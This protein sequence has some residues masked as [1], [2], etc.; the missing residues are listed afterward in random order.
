M[1]R[2]AYVTSGEAMWRFAGHWSA[3]D[4]EA[5]SSGLLE[6]ARSAALEEH[7]LICERCM[8]ELTRIEL[9]NF[10][11][12][13]NNGPFY[14]RITLLATGKFLARHWGKCIEGGRE[15][16]TRAGAKA[17]LLRSFAQ[18]FPEHVCTPRCGPTAQCP[19]R[20]ADLEN[21]SRGSGRARRR[22][23]A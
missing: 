15:F 18:M 22:L 21:L 10:V 17:Y 23:R 11:H 4:L 8:T 1:L 13:T 9:H 5:Y 2:E 16:R 12:F 6:E 20:P 14:S 3:R 7:L 19:A